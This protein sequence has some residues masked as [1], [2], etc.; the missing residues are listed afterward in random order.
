MFRFILIVTILLVLLP[1]FLF[2]EGE[3]VAN[4]PPQ[5]YLPI[6]AVLGIAT[7]FLSKFLGPAKDILKTISSSFVSYERVYEAAK[8]LL[9]R[10]DRLRP[11]ADWASVIIATIIARI[12]KGTPLVQIQDIA[13][14]KFEEL[15]VTKQK[16]LIPLASDLANYQFVRKAVAKKL[17]QGLRIAEEISSN[18]G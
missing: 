4:L 3:T 17:I 18:K 1:V 9:S 12:P 7:G 2:A 15:P 6:A 16:E 13:V 11:F 5:W 8:I 14:S 10:S